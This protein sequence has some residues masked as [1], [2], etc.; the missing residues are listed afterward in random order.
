MAADA[1]RHPVRPWFLTMMGTHHGGAV[2]LADGELRS[3]T[4]TVVKAFARQ[5][6]AAQQRQIRQLQRWNA[7]ETAWWFGD[8]RGRDRWRWV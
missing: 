1:A 6:V 5:M 8:D 3:G 7:C 2:E 4:A